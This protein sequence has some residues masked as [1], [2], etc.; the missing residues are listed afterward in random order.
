MLDSDQNFLPSQDLP[1]NLG[2]IF[3][4]G[5]TL[6]DLFL[7][8]LYLRKFPISPIK[9]LEIFRII[10]DTWILNDRNAIF[11]IK[12]FLNSIVFTFY[13]NNDSLMID[14]YLLQHEC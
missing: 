14:S 5:C 7:F 2:C 10:K 6:F 11:Q 9:G 13:K 12:S 4:F 1:E 8:L 3:D